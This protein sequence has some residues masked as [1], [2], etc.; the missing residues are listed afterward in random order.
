MCAGLLGKAGE[1]VSGAVEGLGKTLDQGAQHVGQMVQD[2][3]ASIDSA[4]KT[5]VDQVSPGSGKIRSQLKK[6]RGEAKKT[7]GP[8][9]TGWEI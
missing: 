6:L 8:A 4:I 1:A 3:A 2:G 9:P 7:K 5:H